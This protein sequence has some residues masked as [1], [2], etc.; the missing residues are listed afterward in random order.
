MVHVLRRGVLDA[1]LST[2]LPKLCASLGVRAQKF[3]EAKITDKSR[4]MLGSEFRVYYPED[5]PVHIIFLLTKKALNL[6]HN[7]FLG[8]ICHQAPM[9]V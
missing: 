4:L 9:W 8:A 2:H 7:C 3:E 5:R 1:N 6:R